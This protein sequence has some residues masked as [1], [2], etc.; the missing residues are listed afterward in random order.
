MRFSNL[1]CASALL[2]SATIAHC[3]QGAE[4]ELRAPNTHTETSPFT[5]TEAALKAWKLPPGFK[6]SLFAAEPDIR[7]PIGMTWDAKGRLWVAENYTYAESPKNFDNSLRDRILI[8][9]DTDQD[10]KFDKRTVFWDKGIKLTSM[11][12]GFGGVYALCAP[13]MLFIPDR[14]GDDIPDGEPEVLLDGFEAEGVRHNI[15]NGLKWGPDGWLY[16][17]HG[18]LSTSMVGKPGTEQKDRTPMNCAIWRWHPVTKNFEVVL[19]GTTNPWGHDWDQHGQLF[20]INTVI[21]HLWHVVP[22]AY[23]K[24]MYG[25]HAN[26]HLYELLDQT[27]DHV[28]WDTKERWDDIRKGVT[29]STSQQG[30]GHAHSGFM[31]YQGNNWPADY[32]NHAFT[33]NFHGRRLNQDSI[34]RAGA[35]Y[36][37][38]HRPD[39]AGTEDPW[40][41]AV[42]LDY[43]PDGG[44]YVLDWTD[45]GECHENDGVHRTSGRIYKITYGDIE[46]VPNRD[47]TKLSNAELIKLLA[48]DNE[49]FARKAAHVLHERAVAGGNMAEVHNALRGAFKNEASVPRKLRA[50]WSLYTTGGADESFLREQLKDPSEFI[51]AWAIQLLIDHKGP[52][53]ALTGT[54]SAVAKTDPSGLVLAFLTSTLHKTPIAQRWQLAETIAGRQEFAKDPALPLL[55]WYGLEPAILS[56]PA[57]A[58]TL[59]RSAQMPKVR[60]FLA[61]RLTG[62]LEKNPGAINSLVETL[63]RLAPGAQADVLTGMSQALH[64]W[65]KAQAPS[66]WSRVAAELSKSN[67]PDTAT[68][69]RELSLVFGDGRAL[70]ELKAIVSNATGDVVA[71]RRALEGLVQARAEGL[72]PLIRPLLSELEVG[73]DAV[74]ALGVIGAAETPELL[75]REY[76][77]FRS[78]GA[79]NEAITALVSRPTTAPLLLKAV[80]RGDIPK[81]HVAAYQLQQLRTLN[82]PEIDAAVAKIWPELPARSADK[83]AQ[84]Q[85]YAA[86]LTLARIKSG[87]P[88]KGREIYRAS[89]GACHKLYSEGGEVGPD[90]TGSDR[91]NMAYLLDN[92]IDPSGIVPENFRASTVTLKDGRA[93]NG[94]VGVTNDR[95]MVLQTPTEKMTLD[96]RDIDSVEQ[97]TLSLMPEGLFESLA[98]KDLIDLVAYLVS[99]EP[100]AKK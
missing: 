25:E 53:I 36:V 8:F 93:L 91:R 45:I 24:R 4:A 80:E 39:F 62:E 34:E 96:R 70:E 1:V 44:V 42:E 90:I 57:A 83:R 48:Q 43:G 74:R 30:G 41:R 71:R 66:A 32:R 87:D 9:E 18:I 19:R 17:R 50:L 21:G 81:Q 64:G 12:V 22:G 58:L 85:K 11:A 84:I 54:F 23:T 10:G 38:K 65:R 72:L 56:N 2:F 79:R 67:N 92:V 13:Q 60:T 6:I 35:T 51:R 5:T 77:N 55:V 28:H 27:A 7:Q 49:W 16:G 37:A 40:Y 100:P 75:I 26:P 68:V 99:E 89:C 97:S 69:L 3:A 20:F 14:N 63:P 73:P 52:P 95:T 78:G 59:L 82:S 86:L 61:R 47:L 98:E 15:V 29:A 31:I 46:K 76:K 94:V 88:T 33:L